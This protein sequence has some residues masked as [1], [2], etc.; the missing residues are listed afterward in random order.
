M[1]LKHITMAAMTLF[2]LYG[3]AAQPGRALTN[4][5]SFKP[6][7]GLGYSPFLG[8]ESPNYGTYPTT[9]DIAF[10]LTNSVTFLA[11]EIRTFGMD[12]TQSNIAGICSMYNINCFPCAYLNPDDPTDNTNELNALVAVANANYP[13]TRGL[14]VGTEPININ[15][16]PGLLISNIDYVRAATHTNYPIG[17]A[18]IPQ[19][20][21]SNPD[22]VAD[23]DFVMIN[24][25]P[26]WAKLPVNQAA[27][28]TLQVWQ[29]FT[30]SFPGKR[31]LIGE[32]GWPTGGTNIYWSDPNVV[33]SAANQ[34]IYLSQFIP[35]AKKNN[36]EYFIFDYRDELWKT[37]SG[38][39]MVDQNW[40]LLDTNSIKKQGLVDYLAAGFSMNIRA[41]ANNAVTLSAQT[42]ENNP[43]TLFSSTNL[44]S[45]FG[46]P[47]TN[48]VGLPGT[49]QTLVT[50]TNIGNQAAGFY[51]A[52]QNF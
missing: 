31:V 44:L 7:V 40:G 3:A 32:T 5:P 10:D 47:I 51:K 11:S 16:D 13:T 22:V 34:G 24:V 45:G 18:D 42:Y 15:Y 1:S 23:L 38:N 48:F 30:N 28:F 6:F 41:V 35:I 9:N 8:D 20:F 12:G 49:N 52:A 21:T 39:G 50:V 2:W 19:S 27:T 25:H 46:N 29:A 36:I 4:I 43:Y 14:I 33:P 26:Y 17:T 37:Q